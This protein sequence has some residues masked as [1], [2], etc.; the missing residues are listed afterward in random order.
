MHA[1]VEEGG[2]Q[3]EWINRVDQDGVTPAC[4]PLCQNA[5]RKAPAFDIIST[6]R[7]TSPWPSSS[8][9][10]VGLREPPYDDLRSCRNDIAVGELRM[11]EEE[12][13]DIRSWSSFISSTSDGEGGFTA[14]VD[15]DG[16]SVKSV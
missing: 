6:A 14:A 5:P 9:P 10:L 13:G 4:A 11:G 15:D 3:I 12:A 2:T 8:D 7:P 16:A 1:S